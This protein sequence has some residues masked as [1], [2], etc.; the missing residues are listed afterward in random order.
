[1]RIDAE[2]HALGGDRDHRVIENSCTAGRP[3]PAVA[4]T[5]SMFDGGHFYLNDHLDAVAQLVSSE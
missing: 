4:F 1:M 2:I 5:L 3:T